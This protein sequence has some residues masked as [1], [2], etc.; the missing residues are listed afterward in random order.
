MTATRTGAVKLRFVDSVI[1]PRRVASVEGVPVCPSSEPQATESAA[2]APA[3]KARERS[4]LDFMVP[5]CL[6]RRSRTPNC[7]GLLVHLQPVA[8]A[9][10][11][12]E[13]SWPHRIPLELVSQV[14]HVHVQV[15]L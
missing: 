15:L 13:K 12:H 8:D 4:A 1:S 10:F 3:S 11:G 5:P 7:K 2:A 6:P 9:R 14:A